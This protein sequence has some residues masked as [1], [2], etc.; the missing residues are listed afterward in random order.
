[1]EWDTTAP[2]DDDDDDRKPPAPTDNEDRKP[3]APDDDDE[4]CLTIKLAWQDSIRISAVPLPNR[5]LNPTF[6]VKDNL[7]IRL[8][9]G[10]KISCFPDPDAFQIL[11]RQ[12]MQLKLAL[13]TQ[14]DNYLLGAIQRCL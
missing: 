14:T 6:S 3:P 11:R 12:I 1:M 7:Y 9:H 2:N 8:N 13:E 4:D 10:S 5:Y